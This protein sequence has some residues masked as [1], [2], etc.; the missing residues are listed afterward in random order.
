MCVEQAYVS[1]KAAI[2]AG[3]TLLEVPPRDL[4]HA[5]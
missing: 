1:T 2:D 4:E 5:P 3:Y